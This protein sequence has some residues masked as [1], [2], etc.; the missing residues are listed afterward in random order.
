VTL[1][2]GDVVVPEPAVLLCPF[3]YF[4]Q[5]PGLE[6]I[7]A[8]ATFSFFSHEAR[9]PEY[10]E[11]LRDRRAADAKSRSQLGDRCAAV[12]QAIEDRAPSGV[13]DCVE[14]IGVRRGTRHWFGK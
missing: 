14:D 2:T 3:R 13:G 5:T 9:A 6:L 7:D 12:S 11:V 1:E 4:F 8:L 10:A